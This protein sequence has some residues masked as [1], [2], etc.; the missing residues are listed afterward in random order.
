[1]FLMR[2]KDVHTTFQASKSVILSSA[3]TILAHLIFCTVEYKCENL[4]F[5]DNTLKET[6]ILV[7]N[8]PWLFF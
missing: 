2:L 4:S 6:A 1:M 5:N 7:T 8:S 3:R